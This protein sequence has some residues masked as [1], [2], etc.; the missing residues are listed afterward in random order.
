MKI[1][2]PNCKRLVGVTKN[3]KTVVKHRTGRSRP[4]N[5]KPVCEASGV[6]L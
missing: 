1:K 2:C 4:H 5:V 6:A 3:P